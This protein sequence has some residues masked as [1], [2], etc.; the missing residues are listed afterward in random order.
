MELKENLMKEIGL[1]NSEISVYVLLVKLGSSKASSL[2]RELGL[3]RSRIYEALSRLMDKGLVSSVIKNNIK[4]FSASNPEKLLEYVEEQKAKLES[5]QESIKKLLPELKKQFE[6]KPEAE[7]RVLYGKEGF[8][9]M[10]NDCLK[11]KKDIYLIGGKGKEYQALEFF[12]PG[13]DK[14]RIKLGIRFRILA[15]FGVQDI[16]ENK[17]LKLAEFKTLPKDFSSPAV[18]NIYGDRVV[19]VLWKNLEPICFMIINKDIADSYRK[20]FEL[21]WKN[22]N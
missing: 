4:Y 7:A 1:P 22:S 16:K 15:D 2:V 9:T 12:F 6:L 10:R 21:M 5:K 20:W 13:F 8:K 19:N 14:K 18:I 17:E 11:Q 3:H